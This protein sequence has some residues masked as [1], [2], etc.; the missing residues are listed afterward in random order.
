[1]KLINVE[2]FVR[3]MTIHNSLEFKMMGQC[4]MVVVYAPNGMGKTTIQ[5]IFHIKKNTAQ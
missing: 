1:M 5:G 3:I 2:I 4:G